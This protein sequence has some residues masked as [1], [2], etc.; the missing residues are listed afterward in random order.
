MK[1][2]IERNEKGLNIELGTTEWDHYE[3]IGMLEMAKVTVQKE[4]E[5]LVKERAVTRQ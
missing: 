5:R 4:V 2:T 3:V 1:I